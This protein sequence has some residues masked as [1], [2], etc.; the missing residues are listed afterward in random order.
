MIMKFYEHGAKQITAICSL[1]QNDN[2]TF[3]WLCI[4]FSVSFRVN[5]KILISSAFSSAQHGN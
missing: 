2:Y 1:K 4:Q 3:T 5:K